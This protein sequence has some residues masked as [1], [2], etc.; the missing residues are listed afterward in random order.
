MHLVPRELEKLATIFSLGYLAQR[1]LARGV[2]LNHAEAILIRDG[3]YAVADLMSIGRTILGRRQVLPSTWFTARQIQVEGTFPT[4]TYLV[5]VVD[6]IATENGDMQRALYGSCIQVPTIDLFPVLTPTDYARDYAPD[7]APGYIW[8]IDDETT[9]ISLCRD[10][11]RIKLKVVNHGN[12][13]IQ[14]GSHYHFIETNRMLSFNRK[15]AQGYRLDLPAGSAMRFEPGQCRETDLVFIGGKKQI[16]GGNGIAT[17]IV[18][19]VNVT[20]P[21]DFLNDTTT[22]KLDKRDE[23]FMERSEY[24]KMFGPTTGDVVRLGSTELYVAKDILRR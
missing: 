20:I 21:D 3:H 18:G 7:K 19:H 17:G 1:R 10:R 14:V 24:V 15:L 6:P 22:G 13:P 4:G 11:D 8:C 5:T 9:K 23:R 12:R 16:A 2:R